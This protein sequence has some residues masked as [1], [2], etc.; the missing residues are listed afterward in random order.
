MFYCVV[1]LASDART[2]VALPPKK[3]NVLRFSFLNNINKR[4]ITQK[5]ILKLC[6][7]VMCWSVF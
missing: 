1:K 4:K 3:G 7:M 5:S 2:C 6:L